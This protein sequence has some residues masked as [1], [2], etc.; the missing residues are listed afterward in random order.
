LVYSVQ[1]SDVEYLFSRGELLLEK[2]RLTRF[3]LPSS[4]EAINDA[5]ADIKQ[6]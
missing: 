2:G 1:G 5:W 4:I 6:R 3:D